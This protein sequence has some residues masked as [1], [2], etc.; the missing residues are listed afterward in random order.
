M[1]VTLEDAGPCRKVM[2]VR[3]GAQE[4]RDDYAKL[5]N[6]YAKQA[7][8]AGFRKGKA[9][10]TVIER[11]FKD[12][13]AEHAKEELVPRL[14]HDALKQ[15]NVSA[16]AIVGVTDVQFSK[17]EGIDF[18]VTLDVAPQFKL[19][20][21]KKIS[22]K[23][24]KVEV[25]D[26]QVDET[27]DRIRESRARFEDV[28]SREVRDGDLVK[29]DYSGTCEGKPFAEVAPENSGLGEGTDFL[30]LVGG[31]EIIPGLGAGLVGAAIGDKR[32]VDVA[33]PEDYRVEPLAGK[34]AVFDVEIKGIREKTLPEL[35]ESLLKEFEVE[36]EDELRGKV[37]EDIQAAA[38]REEEGRLR[39]EISKHLLEKTH[40]DLPQAIV[41]QETRLAARNIVRRI[42]SEGG[43]QEQIA[44]QQDKILDTAAETSKERVKLAYILSRIADEEGISVEDDEVESRI[45]K[46]AEYYRMPVEQFRAEL[47]KRDGVENLRSDIRSEKTLDFLMENAKIKK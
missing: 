43:T 23:R 25:E 20:R 4:V 35:D 7:K 5:V 14:Y 34:Q 30:V 38:E 1:D 9:P 42:A 11:Q 26:K 13:L 6:L 28:D 31:V 37:R 27:V 15:E 36:S 33:F 17:D 19:P 8:V 12:G 41:E 21:Y 39:G 3:A 32:T 22:L 44:E 18:K 2:R 16:V 10:A 45:G 47:E 24:Q 40:F 29:I 46:L